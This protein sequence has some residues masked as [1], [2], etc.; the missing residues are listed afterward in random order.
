M[1]LS[2][3]LGKKVRLMIVKEVEF[4]VYLGSSQEKV[5]L[6]NIAV[7]GR[8]LILH[9]HLLHFPGSLYPLKRHLHI[10]AVGIV[11]W[12]RGGLCRGGVLLTFPGH[13]GDTDVNGLQI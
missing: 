5:L 12:R 2:E 3:N 7:H 4:G 1:S 13:T 8:L 11:R 10:L 6:N 9:P